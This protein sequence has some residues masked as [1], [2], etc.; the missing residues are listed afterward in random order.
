[1][2]KY[3]SELPA[4]TTPAE[5][6]ELIL[7]MYV[8]H[9]HGTTLALVLQPVIELVNSPLPYRATKDKISILPPKDEDTPNLLV[10]K[11]CK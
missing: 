9:V 7:S 10:F 5:L 11:D 3:L 1:M 6:K 2:A 8:G 4:S